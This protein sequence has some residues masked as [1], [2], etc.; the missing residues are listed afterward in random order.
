L[1]HYGY[2]KTLRKLKLTKPLV[3]TIV[4]RLNRR[5]GDI[6]EN[7]E[8]NIAAALTPQSN[9]T[10]LAADKRANIKASFLI[11]SKQWIKN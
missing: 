7:D 6:L 1:N 11:L 2:Q 9:L 4:T 3:K 5:F 8:Y 10:Y